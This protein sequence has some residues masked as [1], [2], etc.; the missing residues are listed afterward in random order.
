[1]NSAADFFGGFSG[2]Y[3]DDDKSN[4]N[5]YSGQTRESYDSFA[6]Y[7]HEL[8]NQRQRQQQKQ[9]QQQQRYRQQ[10]PKQQQAYRP[11]FLDDDPEDRT[12]RPG[13]PTVL[14]P[15]SKEE[16]EEERRVKAE[17]DR[18]RI[19]NLFSIK[20]SD[21]PQDFAFRPAQQSPINNNNKKQQQPNTSVKDPFR[22]AHKQQHNNNNNR[23]RK[24]P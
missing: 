9:Q 8:Q 2:Y 23:S 19:R 10:R 12:P 5:D 1:M 11:D 6:G 22:N 3:E 21:K 13:E 18:E 4:N 17:T 16:E 15:T 14:S 20:N 24:G 7:D